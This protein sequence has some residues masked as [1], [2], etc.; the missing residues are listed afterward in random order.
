MGIQSL[1]ASELIRL[2]EVLRVPNPFFTQGRYRFE[3]IE[4]VSLLCARFRSAGDQYILSLLYD[5]PQSA[6]SEVVNELVIYLAEKW[7]HLLD[8]DHEGLLSRDKLIWRAIEDSV[9]PAMTAP[10]VIVLV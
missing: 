10:G 8:F 7:A 9:H 4:A 6:I 5:R 3:A 2:A 1:T